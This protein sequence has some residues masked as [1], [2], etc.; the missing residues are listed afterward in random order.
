MTTQETND[1]T[2]EF[3]TLVRGHIEV[4]IYYCKTKGLFTMK[5][6]SRCKTTIKTVQGFVLKM[7][8]N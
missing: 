3:N 6:M 4:F 1:G 5:S 2:N 8:I 7:K